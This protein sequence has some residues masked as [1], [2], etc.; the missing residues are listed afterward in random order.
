METKMEK[1]MAT[2]ITTITRSVKRTQTLLKEMEAIIR[3]QHGGEVPSGGADAPRVQ[4]E[5]LEP[6]PR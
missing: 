6:T 2:L 5:P 4:N 1:L 3:L